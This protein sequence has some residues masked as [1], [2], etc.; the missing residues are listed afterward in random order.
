MDMN[1]KKALIIVSAILLVLFVVSRFLMA[2]LP[3]PNAPL[4]PELSSIHPAELPKDREE[5]IKLISGHYAHYD[6][7]AYEDN[8]TSMP[9]R[10]FIVS[11]G[12]TDFFVK[13]NKLYQKDSFVHAEQILNQRF[14]KSSLSDKATRA[15]KPATTEVELVF[16]DGKWTIYRPETPSLIGI[17]GDPAI[18]LD[19][20]DNAEFT[21]PDED[22]NPG[23][24]VELN[25]SGLFKGKIFIARREIFRDYLTVYSPELIMG[26]VEDLSEQ[27]VIGASHDFLAVKSNNKQHPDPSMNPIILKRVDDDIDTWEELR[28]IRDELFPKLP[29][30]Y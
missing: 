4:Y 27:L 19:A 7:V 10:T 18:S 16:S 23:V 9:M 2:T 8:S 30:F 3:W 17:K 11:Y 26:Y 22:G 1:V 15:I 28:E 6:I 20:Q 25:I 21:D 13:D 12:F 24:T 5:V 29:S 14:T